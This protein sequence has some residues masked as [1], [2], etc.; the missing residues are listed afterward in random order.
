MVVDLTK[1]YVQLWM[2]Q[3]PSEALLPTAGNWH[4]DD[5][6]MKTFVKIDLIFSGHPDTSLATLIRRN[7]NRF[8]IQKVKFISKYK[9]SAKNCFL[10][11]DICSCHSQMSLILL[12]W[13]LVISLILFTNGFLSS[14]ELKSSDPL[15]D[16][17]SFWAHDDNR[18]PIK[19]SS[20][21]YRQVCVNIY[22]IVFK[23]L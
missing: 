5:D 2:G 8:Q 9:S 21:Q 23:K 22:D 3:F 17:A 19:V 6:D 7:C 11:I 4:R 18:P 15:T 10:F 12:S 14:S 1:Q 20:M 16:S 13:K